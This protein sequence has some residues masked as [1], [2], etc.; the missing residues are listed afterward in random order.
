MYHAI[1]EPVRFC[2]YFGEWMLDLN[3]GNCDDFDLN[4]EL[5]IGK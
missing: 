4:G 3:L 2:V 1:I 5:E